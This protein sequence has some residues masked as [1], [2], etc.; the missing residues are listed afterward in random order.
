MIQA[1][2]GKA[3][4]LVL[5]F[6]AQLRNERRRAHYLRR[7]AQLS[8]LGRAMQGIEPVAYAGVM[9][10]WCSICGRT[11]KDMNGQRI[12]DVLCQECA[13]LLNDLDEQP[14][15]PPLTPEAV[16]VV[17]QT[18]DDLTPPRGLE[19]WL[20]AVVRVDCRRL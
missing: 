12:W 13:E 10:A 6:V 1:D 20:G 5:G 18:C 11:M 9:P 4:A 3:V 14:T 17:R 16:A 7:L 19:R 2:N 15:P 8:G